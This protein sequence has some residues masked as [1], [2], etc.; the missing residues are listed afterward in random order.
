[1]GIEGVSRPTTF[2]RKSWRV[3]TDGH[4]FTC[5]AVVP[6]SAGWRHFRVY[7]STYLR[8][9]RRAHLIQPL[10]QFDL[11]LIRGLAH[12]AEEVLSAITKLLAQC[13]A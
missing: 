3:E 5:V 4:V 2:T 9:P 13:I 8:I 7:Q 12:I 10:A 6:R 11:T 1:M